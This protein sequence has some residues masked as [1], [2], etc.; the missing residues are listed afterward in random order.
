MFYFLVPS[1]RRTYYRIGKVL[2]R[3]VVGHSMLQATMD[4]MP[5][6][7]TF[8]TDLLRYE[9]RRGKLHY[10]VGLKTLIALVNL[11]RTNIFK[12]KTALQVS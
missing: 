11:R 12:V 6:Y 7:C 8:Y 9:V 5:N 10:F 4:F 1:S 2:A 3:P